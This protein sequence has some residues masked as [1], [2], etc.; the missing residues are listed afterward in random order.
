MDKAKN[1]S[2]SSIF[3]HPFHP[4]LVYFIHFYSIYT[5]HPFPF[6]FIH[7]EWSKSFQQFQMGIVKM[8]RNAPLK[9]PTL[10]S[11]CILKRKK[12]KKRLAVFLA[13]GILCLV[14]IIF[15]FTKMVEFRVFFFS[16]FFFFQKFIKWLVYQFQ[17]IKY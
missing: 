3:I 14:F 12:K 7:L 8:A 13:F 16:K 15:L 9:Q 11:I 4:F 2:I 10:P 6:H 1:G 17:Y 5:F